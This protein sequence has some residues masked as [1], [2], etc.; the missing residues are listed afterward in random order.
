M[1]SSALDSSSLLLSY[2]FMSLA[3]SITNILISTLFQ[4]SEHIIQLYYYTIIC[5]P[6][7][8]SKCPIRGLC[9]G[10]QRGAQERRKVGEVMYK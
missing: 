6:Y 7:A 4:T 8:R 1:W 5:M 10:A 3:L 9:R 2:S